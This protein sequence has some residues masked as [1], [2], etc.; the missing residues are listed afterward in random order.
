[1]NLK[2]S[3]QRVSELRKIVVLRSLVS[4]RLNKL[5]QTPQ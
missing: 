5:K 3:Q 1:M 4:L 2:N